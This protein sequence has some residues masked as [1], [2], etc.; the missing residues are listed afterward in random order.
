MSSVR[1]VARALH[2]VVTSKPPVREWLVILPDNAQVARTISNT[3]PAIHST[4]K[5]LAGP[6]YRNP[7]SALPQFRAPP[8]GGLCLLGRF[9]SLHLPILVSI[10]P[11][12]LDYLEHSAETNTNTGPIFAR[13]FVKGPVENR[14]F[15]GSVMIVNDTDPEAIRAKLKL[16]IYTQERIWDWENAEILPFHTL[17][18]SPAELVT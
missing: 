14:P 18:R 8:Q 11:I 6:P 9:V 5:V 7:A 17:E 16:D 10:A 3:T 12:C 15:V 2:T 13:P 1:T 4:N